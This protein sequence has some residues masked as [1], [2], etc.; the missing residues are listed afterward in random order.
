MD[1]IGIV[2]LTKWI[3]INPVIKVKCIGTVKADSGFERQEIV[4]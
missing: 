3:A 2:Q 4:V 1:I